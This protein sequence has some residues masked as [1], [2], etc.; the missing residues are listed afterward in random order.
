MSD[1]H[2]GCGEGVDGYV[3]YKQAFDATQ[4]GGGGMPPRGSGDNCFTITI[5]IIYV[6]LICIAGGICVVLFP[7]TL[8]MAAD[9]D[10]SAGYLLPGLAAAIGLCALMRWKYKN[11]E[12]DENRRKWKRYA[13][14]F[15]LFMLADA[16][17]SML[18]LRG[19]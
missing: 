11:A 7:A 19:M 10:A 17:I 16:I 9:G 4:K 8:C 3:H 15:A 1:D 2:G 18:V 14:Y 6:G 5:A 12:T 13:F